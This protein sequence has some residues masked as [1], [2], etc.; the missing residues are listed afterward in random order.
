MLTD[1][2]PVASMANDQAGAASAWRD[3]TDRPTNPAVTG[4]I[5]IVS[6]VSSMVQ[7][8]NALRSDDPATRRAGA[9]T[10]ANGAF[11]TASGVT[12]TVDGLRSGVPT[13]GTPTVLSRVSSGLNAAGGAVE[14]AQ[15]ADALMHAQ[16]RDQLTTGTNQ[17]A[18]G[19]LTMGS[20]IPPV[21]PL[22]TTAAMAYGTGAALVNAGDEEARSNGM[23]GRS[24]TTTERG[25]R[26]RVGNRSASEAA[27]D[28]GMDEYQRSHS[29]VRGAM[30]AVSAQ[31]RNTTGA[32][33][34]RVEHM[35]PD[36]L[37][38]RDPG[39]IVE[40][41][42]MSDPVQARLPALQGAL[43]RAHATGQTEPAVT[44]LPSDAERAAVQTILSQPP[45]AGH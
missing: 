36:A 33:A 22:F 39:V 28:A 20:A 42:D 16:T 26:G 32:L 43:D 38:T 35:M 8:R 21:A 12:S 11:G 37:R 1:L 45:R 7:G 29:H 25:I 18:H 27:D 30:A 19:V 41:P 31:F 10:I 44:V 2:A 9:Y 13:P 3:V 5:S 40:Q 15:G 17:V 6:G 23:F 14:T 4:P 24:R 34:S